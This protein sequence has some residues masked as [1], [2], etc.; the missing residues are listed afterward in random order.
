MNRTTP[1]HRGI[2]ASGHPLVSQAAID[3]MMNGGNAF[4][5][6]VGAGFVSA[7]AEPALTSLG[8]GGFLLA[9]CQGKSTL[10]DFFA[11]TPGKGLPASDLSPHFFPLTVNFPGSSQ[12]FNIGHGSVAVPG[13]LR[14]YLHVHGKLGRLPRREVL[15]PVIRHCLEG[16]RINARQAYFLD[17]LKPIMTLTERGKKLYRDEEGYLREGSLFFNPEL[18]VFLQELINA[19][20]PLFYEGELAARIAEEMHLE[21]GLLTKEDLASFRVIERPPLQTEYGRRVLL[22]NPPPSFG[23]TLIFLALQLLK[24]CRLSEL[25]WGEAPHLLAV[26]E[27]MRQVEERRQIDEEGL[28]FEKKQAWCREA[29]QRIKMFSR[30]TTHLSII[31]PEGNVASMTTSN[32]EGSGYIAPGTGIMLNNM[33]GEDD[34]HPDGFH[35]APPGKRISSMMSPTIALYE[36]QPEL[37]LGSGGSKRIRTAITQVLSNLIDF[38]MA[39]DE[40]VL[41]PRLHWDGKILQVEPGFSKPVLQKMREK[42]AINE[43]LETNMYF[44]GV[45][46]IGKGFGFG[47]PRRG[48]DSRCTEDF[49]G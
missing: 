29:G 12:I 17:I 47:D 13:N 11:D 44:G 36:G 42:F 35:S 10:F 9:H 22:T 4:D 19:G 43:W 23:G 3:I 40:A 38:N 25:S 5:A 33:M 41:S 24:Q 31:D 7:V 18:A 16:I 28:V 2:V 1:C 32:G 27:T 21:K 8:G 49:D 6:A 26:A 37:V 14:G 39:V 34:L 46:A 45:H 20:D 30:G 15:A 48:G